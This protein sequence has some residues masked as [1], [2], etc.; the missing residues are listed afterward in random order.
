MPTGSSPRGSSSATARVIGQ[1]LERPG[2]AE[3]LAALAEVP[4]D[5]PPLPGTYLPVAPGLTTEVPTYALVAAIRDDDTNALRGTLVFESDVASD[6]ALNTQIAP[7]RHGDTGNYLIF[8]SSG[9]VIAATNPSLVAQQ[10]PDESY[11]TESP[12]FHRAHGQVM[13]LAD[14]PAAGWRIVFVQD[15]AEFE[16]GLAGPLQ[17]AGQIVVVAFLVFGLIAFVALARRLRAAR[18]EQARLQRLTESQEEFISIVSHELRTPVAG[19]LGFLQ[20]T[21]DHWESMSE[22]ERFNALRRSASNA[23]RLQG[24]TRDV[25]DSQAVES[26]RMSYAMGD[27]DLG[28]EVRVAVEAA[29]ALYPRLHLDTDLEVDSA[30]VHVDVDRIQQVLTNLLDNAAKASPPDGTIS[31]RMW[32]DAGRVLVLGHRPGPRPVARDARSRVRQVRARP[33]VQRLRNGP[34]AVHLASDPRGPRRLDLGQRAIRWRGDVHVRAAAP[35][36]GHGRVGSAGVFIEIVADVTD[37]LVEAYQRLI[38]Q[39]SSSNPPP[40]REALEDIVAA[41]A[42]DVFV[43][44]DD[45]GRIL[46]TATLAVFRIPTGRRAWI[47]DVVVDEAATGQGIGGLLTRAMIDR[48][49]EL[50]CTT[51]D[52]TSRPSRAAANRL[53]QREGF[54]IRDTN[55]YRYDLRSE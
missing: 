2:F 16:K 55:V 29:S 28:E 25:L 37:E 12:G 18:D 46:G 22:T 49:E 13:V 53:Y 42:T 4:A 19:V 35:R 21:M 52:L 40:S 36:A 45:E 3:A 50:G 1:H 11:R 5:R 9:T 38:P 34:G 32:T 30:P 7:L 27:A 41:P 6:S 33:D 48:A 24:L 43:A 51:V 15:S 20:T 54:E 8:G 44:T 47:E 17:R 39:L 31:V 14:I 23:R 26:G 10:V